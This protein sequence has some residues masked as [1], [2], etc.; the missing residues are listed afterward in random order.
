MY[1]IYHSCAAYI[2]HL[3]G[4]LCRIILIIMIV[5]LVV[6]VVVCQMRLADYLITLVSVR[7]CVCVSVHRS[8]V[9]RFTSAI[10]YR[11]LPNFA[12]RSEMWLFL[13]QTGSRLPI[14]EMCKIQFWQFHNCVGH[15]FPRIVT[16]T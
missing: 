9:E 7:L 11:F 8:V 2:E 4:I 10:L 14:L 12:C 15:I 3:N 13:G 5:M 1:S 6:V 16:K